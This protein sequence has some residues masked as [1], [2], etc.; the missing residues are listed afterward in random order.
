MEAR[1]AGKSVALTAYGSR[2]T[3]LLG[4]KERS[5]FLSSAAGFLKMIQ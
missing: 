2:I 1:L 3:L 5:F 4:E